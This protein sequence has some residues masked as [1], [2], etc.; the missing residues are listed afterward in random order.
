MVCLIWLVATVGAQKAY[1]L[2]NENWIIP[3]EGNTFHARD[4]LLPLLQDMHQEN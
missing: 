3:H 1:A 4:I 2:E